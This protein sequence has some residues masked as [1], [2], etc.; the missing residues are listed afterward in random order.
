[1]SQYLIMFHTLEFAHCKIILN[2]MPQ[3][4]KRTDQ[5]NTYAKSSNIMV[6]RYLFLIA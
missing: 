6:L 2:I 3:V 4:T 5:S 1:M